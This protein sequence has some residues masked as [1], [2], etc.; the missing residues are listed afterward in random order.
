MANGDGKGL[1]EKATSPLVILTTIATMLGTMVGGV[2][3][4]VAKIDASEAKSDSAMEAVKEVK[5]SMDMLI[6]LQRE[7]NDLKREEMREQG[8]QIKTRTTSSSSSSSE[9]S[10]VIESAAREVSVTTSSGII[11]IEYKPDSLRSGVIRKGDTMWVPMAVD[12][13]GTRPR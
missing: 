8:I 7:A 10:S 2:T 5:G 3:W 4:G 9:T 12:T 11:I 6:L 13:V 1:V